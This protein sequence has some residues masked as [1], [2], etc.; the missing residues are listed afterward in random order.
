MMKYQIWIIL[1][2]KKESGF[3]PSLM[4]FLLLLLVLHVASQHGTP[5][6]VERKLLVLSGKFLF[7]EKSVWILTVYQLY[8][9]YSYYNCKSYFVNQYNFNHINTVRGPGG[10]QTWGRSNSSLMFVFDKG[11]SQIHATFYHF[12]RSKNIVPSQSY[13]ILNSW[14]YRELQCLHV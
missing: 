4:L 13:W 6:T 1:K 9:Y 8:S 7:I 14:K 5:L 2:R 3:C 11:E 10:S 12:T